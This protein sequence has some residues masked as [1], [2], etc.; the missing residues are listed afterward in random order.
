M[1]EV[2]LHRTVLD[3]LMRQEG[4]SNAALSRATCISPSTITHL[5]SGRF[6]GYPI[7][8]ERI[9]HALNADANELRKPIGD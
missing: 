3:E 2:E 4:I 5:R 7:Q 8:W 9:E 6:L 1:I